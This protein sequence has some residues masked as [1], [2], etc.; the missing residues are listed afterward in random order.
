MIA[1]G[2]K[3][4]YKGLAGI[5]DSIQ[6]RAVAGSDVCYIDQVKV[7]FLDGSFSW[8]SINQLELLDE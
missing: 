1:V 4:S 6:W 3:V 2:Q 5:V 7:I 8:H